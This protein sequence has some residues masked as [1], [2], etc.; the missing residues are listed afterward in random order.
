MSVEV[1]AAADWLQETREK[2]HGSIEEA[3]GWRDKETEN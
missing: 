2:I 1:T 3:E